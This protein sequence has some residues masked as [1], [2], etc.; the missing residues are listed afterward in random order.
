MASFSVLMVLGESHTYWAQLLDISPPL[1][2]SL[3]FSLSEVRELSSEL[4][5]LPTFTVPSQHLEKNS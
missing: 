4:L 1:Y 2:I 3:S 5:S